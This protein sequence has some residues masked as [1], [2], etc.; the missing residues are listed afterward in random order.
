MHFEGMEKRAVIMAHSFGEVRR[1]LMSADFWMKCLTTHALYVAPENWSDVPWSKMPYFVHDQKRFM[2]SHATGGHVSRGLVSLWKKSPIQ[3]KNLHAEWGEWYPDFGRSMLHDYYS[4]FES[5]GDSGGYLIDACIRRSYQV[6]CGDNPN[7]LVIMEPDYRIIHHTTGQLKNESISRSHRHNSDEDYPYLKALREH[8]EDFPENKALFAQVRLIASLVPVLETLRLCGL[9]P[10]MR[11]H[12][13]PDTENHEVPPVFCQKCVSGDHL[14]YGG[15]NVNGSGIMIPIPVSRQ[16]MASVIGVTPKISKKTHLVLCIEVE[17]WG[18]NHWTRHLKQTV[19]IRRNPD[20]DP[21]RYVTLFQKLWQ[22]QDYVMRTKFE[23]MT[24]AAMLGYAVVVEHYIRDVHGQIQRGVLTKE[25]GD[26]LFGEATMGALHVKIDP[27]VQCRIVRALCATGVDLSLAKLSGYWNDAVATPAYLAVVNKLEPDIFRVLRDRYGEL[28]PFLT[29]AVMGHVFSKVEDALVLDRDKQRQIFL[30]RMAENKADVTRPTTTM[31]A[32]PQGPLNVVKNVDLDTVV[33]NR[34][35]EIHDVLMSDSI[36]KA[37]CLRGLPERPP[38][39]RPRES[40]CETLVGLGMNPADRDETGTLV[41]Q[42]PIK[43][44]HV[45]LFQ[46]LM[47]HGFS[48]KEGDM[49]TGELLRWAFACEGKEM[50]DLVLDMIEN[51]PPELSEWK[52][53]WVHSSPEAMAAGAIQPICWAVGHHQWSWVERLLAMGADLTMVQKPGFTALHQALC[54]RWEA[55]VLAVLAHPDSQTFFD[56]LEGKDSRRP[57]PGRQHGDYVSYAVTRFPE[58]IPCLAARY[59]SRDRMDSCGMS[60]VH[61]AAQLNNVSTLK[62][63]RKQGWNMSQVS[64]DESG[65]SALFY[66]AL[67]SQIDAF[68]YLVSEANLPLLHREK[69]FGNSILHAVMETCNLAAVQS[70]WERDSAWV[71]ATLKQP[72][73]NGRTPLHV[74]VAANFEPFFEWLSAV[75][76]DILRD[77]V[78]APILNAAGE[79][80]LHLAVVHRSFGAM[81]YLLTGEALQVRDRLGRT[82]LDMCTYK[83]FL[84]TSQLSTLLGCSISIAAS[85]KMSLEKSF[86]IDRHLRLKLNEGG[87]GMATS[88]RLALDAYDKVSWSSEQKPYVAALRGYLEKQFDFELDVMIQLL[89]MVNP[90][91]LQ[92]PE[93][94]PQEL[95]VSKK[96]GVLT[97]CLK[98][99]L[100]L[101][102]LHLL[103]PHLIPSWQTV[104]ESPSGCATFFRDQ[105]YVQVS[106]LD[107]YHAVNVDQETHL[108]RQEKLMDVLQRDDVAGFFDLLQNGKWVTIDTLPFVNVFETMLRAHSKK[109]LGII[110]YLASGR[111]TKAMLADIS[112]SLQDE[113]DYLKSFV[114]T[115]SQNVSVFWNDVEHWMIDYSVSHHD[116]FV[117]NTVFERAPTLC[118]ERHYYGFNSEIL[119]LAKRHGVYSLAEYSSHPTPVRLRE[120]S[121]ARDYERLLISLALWVEIQVSDYVKWVTPAMD[122]LRAC[123][124]LWQSRGALVYDY[125]TSANIFRDMDFVQ[126]LL[127]QA[128]DRGFDTELIIPD[129]ETMDPILRMNAAR[130]AAHLLS[131]ELLFPKPISAADRPWV[132]RCVETKQTAILRA[133]LPYLPT[134]WVA[135]PVS[136]SSLVFHYIADKNIPAL[137]TLF[138]AG[139]S[140]EGIFPRLVALYPSFSEAKTDYYSR[141]YQDFLA[142]VIDRRLHSHSKYRDVSSENLFFTSQKLPVNRDSL[143]FYTTFQI[144]LTETKI[145]YFSYKINAAISQFTTRL[146][147]LNWLRVNLKGVAVCKKLY[148]S[149]AK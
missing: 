130:D 61:H 15:A 5:M 97:Y 69:V 92:L 3:P 100:G 42:Y 70:L 122:R 102:K 94:A 64:V 43:A 90:Y 44:N 101:R 54:V 107:R 62:W 89:T 30:S 79:T 142:V 78:D 131:C 72:D 121:D 12:F 147:V 11:F 117:L 134:S 18:A 110:G 58:M 56:D 40:L 51:L 95:G 96:E 143:S 108:L 23:P 45:A 91:L 28:R 149:K 49:P 57:C 103:W 119:N 25:K 39:Y 20:E 55:G 27:R 141:E 8:M 47:S 93:S 144:P 34:H 73:H 80:C 146:E 133:L 29:E 140:S 9:I 85:F 37:A 53:F 1:T 26:V 112:K 109:L 74:G 129:A 63:L 120:L 6:M 77:I 124:E 16:D 123:H 139:F 52:D 128:K 46:Q 87:F 132:E 111:I 10:K 83:H 86:V 35:L 17:P 148:V 75:S 65:G 41:L 116:S 31:V 98:E 114:H 99:A 2:E 22:S 50:G 14:S 127:F 4:Q 21:E 113:P 138:E 105:R 81:P 145:L 88:R 136:E 106:Y 68:R 48:P 66:A 115:I 104:A 60:A 67:P 33:V 82:S 118:R 137:K 32:T 7:P 36:Q 19:T 126:K 24:V 71:K 13:Y 76:P 125:E 135:D 84:S 59:E 38:E